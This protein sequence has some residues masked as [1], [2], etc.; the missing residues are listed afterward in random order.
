MKIY[1]AEVWSEWVHGLSKC[2]FKKH[3]KR[4]WVAYC[5]VRIVAFIYDKFEIIERP[6][7]IVW[8]IKEIKK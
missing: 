2:Y 7:G 3:F 5:A 4:R 6:L 1:V 8:R